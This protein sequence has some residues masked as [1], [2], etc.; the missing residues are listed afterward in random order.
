M[1]VINHKLKPNCF[2]KNKKDIGTNDKYEE[3][4]SCLHLYG[5][6]IGIVGA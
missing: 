4:I 2:D 6:P 3:G 1:Q 5:T